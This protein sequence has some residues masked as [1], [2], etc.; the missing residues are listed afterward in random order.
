MTANISKRKD[1]LG[2][3][4]V[5]RQIE[6]ITS[7]IT[8]A[9]WINP[10]PVDKKKKNLR[11]CVCIF[12]YA[13]S[14]KPHIVWDLCLTYSFGL[15]ITAHAGWVIIIISPCPWHESVVTAVCIRQGGGFWRV[16]ESP[17]GEP[18]A[19]YGRQDYVRMYGF[20]LFS[21]GMKAITGEGPAYCRRRKRSNIICWLHPIRHVTQLRSKSYK[22]APRP[23][24]PLSS[25]RG[26]RGK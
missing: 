5:S 4:N 11:V 18:R 3:V 17:T 19:V 1:V 2:K 22:T 16:P 24:P 23:R 21:R 10:P 9:P 25:G 8:L 14:N 6:R 7:C 12:N 26:R 13:L 15:V 20:I